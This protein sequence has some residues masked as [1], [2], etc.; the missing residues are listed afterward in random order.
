MARLTSQ[1]KIA[2]GLLSFIAIAAL[3]IEVYALPQQ[4]KK[5]FVPKTTQ[6][7]KTLDQ[8]EQERIQLQK[9]S[10]TDFDGLSDYDELYIFHT[11]AYNEDSDSDGI[12][13][14]TEVQSGGDPG[15]PAGKTCRTAPNPAPAPPVGGQ[16]AIPAPTPAPPATDTAI[17]Q[18]FTKAFGD[19]TKL[20]DADI[21]SKVGQM[22]SADLRA[23]LQSIGMPPEAVSK[24]DDATLR[25]L[26]KD[27]LAELSAGK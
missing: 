10:D 14:G 5:P 11:S 8:Q 20:T 9:N 27:T 16:V 7:F 4:M 15:C 23:F 25:R 12:P 17:L 13:D 21:S 1:Q 24:N 18:A 26:L 2:T 19:V 3:S 6:V 22:S